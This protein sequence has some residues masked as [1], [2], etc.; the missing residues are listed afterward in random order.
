MRRSMSRMA[1]TTA[2]M[3]GVG[4]A[5]RWLNSRAAIV[6]SGP[7]LAPGAVQM[8]VGVPRGPT[9]TRGPYIAPVVPICVGSAQVPSMPRRTTIASSPSPSTR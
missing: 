7:P 5:M 2:A 6:T 1:W 3:C 8:T 4:E 9:V